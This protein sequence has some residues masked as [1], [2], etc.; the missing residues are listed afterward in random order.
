MSD[1][2][3]DILKDLRRD[4]GLKLK[5]YIDTVGKLTIGY[6]HN[7]DDLGISVRIAGLMLLEDFAQA[8]A[9]LDR[10]LPWWRNMPE[11]HQ[12]GLAN[13]SFNLGLPKLMKF[14][15]MLA[16]LQD[17]NGKLAKD[18]ALDSKW[19]GQVGERANRIADLY[20]QT[21]EHVFSV[22]PSIPMP[23]GFGVE[24]PPQWKDFL[25][26]HP[27]FASTADSAKL[28]PERLEQLVEVNRLVN[29]GCHY[30]HDEAGHDHWNVM[31][32]GDMGDCEEFVFTKIRLLVEKGWPRGALRPVICRTLENI[33]HMVLSIHTTDGVYI[34]DNRFSYVALWAILPYRW[35]YRLDGSTWRTVFNQEREVT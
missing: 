30:E 26:R 28:T 22:A 35:L 17:G 19:A 3:A 21:S 4:E 29:D 24:A 33:A 23:A 32:I 31:E 34:V 16:A 18:E 7:L 14:K 5:P 10:S 6:G 2:R 13:M 11:P 15:K 20:L 1:L 9:D 8:E 12:R 25:Q 27:E